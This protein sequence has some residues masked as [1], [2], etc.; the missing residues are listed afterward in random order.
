VYAN[1]GRQPAPHRGYDEEEHWFQ[2][3]GCVAQE[4]EHGAYT[5]EAGESSMAEAGISHTSTSHPGALRVTTYTNK[6]LR[7][8]VD[9]SAHQRTSRWA[10]REQVLRAPFRQRTVPGPS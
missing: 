8:V 3:N 5:I 2:F 10:V 9:P 6:R 7:L 1:P 4:T